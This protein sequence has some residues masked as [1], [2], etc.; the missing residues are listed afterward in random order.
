MN[1]IEDD[2]TISKKPQTDGS[3]AGDRPAQEVPLCSHN[4]YCET[5]ACSATKIGDWATRESILRHAKAAAENNVHTNAEPNEIWYDSDQDKDDS[6]DE[7][8]QGDDDDSD[9]DD[10]R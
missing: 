3:G 4:T 9:A 10:G 8:G 6:D 1:K 7:E 2:P 5:T